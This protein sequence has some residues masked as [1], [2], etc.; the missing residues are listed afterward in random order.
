MMLN[1]S[2][3]MSAIIENVTLSRMCKGRRNLNTSVIVRARPGRFLKP[4]DISTSAIKR[5][6]C[7]QKREQAT[8]TTAFWTSIPVWRRSSINT[9]RCLVG[10][11]TGDFSTMWY[12]QA[13]YPELST[14][15]TMG[16]SMS[17]GIMT[18]MAL[19]TFMLRYG[20]DSL[21]W[22]AAI[23]TATGMSMISMLAME[24]AE[25]LVDYTLTGGSIDLASPSFWMS[26]GLAAFAGFLFPLPYNYFRLRTYGKSCH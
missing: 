26:A 4:R 10:C 23:K 3:I 21:S 12:L 13:V 9:M 25:N 20:R 1:S 11:T 14:M 6:G 7:S 15:V 18:S 2:K 8:S 5:G 16:I 17:A 19:E 22:K 24:V